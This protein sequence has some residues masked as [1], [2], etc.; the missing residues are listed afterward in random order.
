MFHL[1]AAG[2]TLLMLSACDSGSS[3]PPAPD[4]IAT[5]EK[6]LDRQREISEY[7]LSVDAWSNRLLAAA[8]EDD[9]D[10][11]EKTAADVRQRVD[12]IKALLDRSRSDRFGGWTPDIAEAAR[13]LGELKDVHYRAIA[14]NVDARREEEREMGERLAELNQSLSDFRVVAS[15]HNASVNPE[16][17]RRIASL[18]MGRRQNGELLRDLARADPLNW[19]YLRRRWDRQIRSWEDDHRMALERLVVVVRSTGSPVATG[20]A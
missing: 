6:G 3:P 2:F 12:R 4:R 13:Q 19:P 16:I 14:A 8:D 1:I 11:A 9:R 20:G 10:L 15:S 5:L 7:L 18:E 17:R